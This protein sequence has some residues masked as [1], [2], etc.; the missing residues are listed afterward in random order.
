MN[1]LKFAEWDKIKLYHFI[2]CVIFFL[3]ISLYYLSIDHFL[4]YIHLWNCHK[5][6]IVYP[7]SI[8]TIYVYFFH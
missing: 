1:V 4:S 7:I 8:L 2:L 5:Y 6:M 3:F